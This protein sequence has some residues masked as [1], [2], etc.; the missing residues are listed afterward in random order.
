MVPKRATFLTYGADEKCADIKRFIEDSGVLLDIR[1]I[2]KKPL[3]VREIESLV[4][5]LDLNHFLNPMS[6]SFEKNGLDKDLPPRDEV[7]KMIV[8][9]HTLLRRPII[10]NNRL[11]TIG[12]DKRKI[13]EMLQISPNGKP[14]VDD[15]KENG[16]AKKEAA[17]ASK[18]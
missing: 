3:T 9:D 2:E 8:E 13:A 15:E 14:P 4:G 1:D 18:S 12:C 11:F 17:G 6:R 16:Q 10:R 5:H 7:I